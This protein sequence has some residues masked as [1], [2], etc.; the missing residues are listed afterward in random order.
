MSL[1]ATGAANLYRPISTYGRTGAE[2]TGRHGHCIIHAGRSAPTPIGNE[3][4]GQPEMVVAAPHERVG[5]FDPR[6][7]ADHDKR[8]PVEHNV[9]RG[10]PSEINRKPWKPMKLRGIAMIRSDRYD[11]MPGGVPLEEAAC[12]SKIK[13]A[14]QHYEKEEDDEDDD[15]DDDDDNDGDPRKCDEN[16]HV[17]LLGI[18]GTQGVDH[19]FPQALIHQCDAPTI[20]FGVLGHAVNKSDG[21]KGGGYG[22][23]DPSILTAGHT[24]QP[25]WRRTMASR[26]GFVIATPLCLRVL[27]NYEQSRRPSGTYGLDSASA[28]AH[29]SAQVNRRISREERLAANVI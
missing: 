15:D 23:D 16:K 8:R 20:C 17:D 13:N 5:G 4:G 14:L 24:S 22:Y 18:V 11:S 7:R 12:W 19:S 25:P 21:F 29:T 10:F 2:K 1:P 27:H 9:A 6:T 28:T 26:I 3:T